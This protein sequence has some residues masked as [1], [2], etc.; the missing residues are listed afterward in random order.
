MITERP[1]EAMILEWKRI[2]ETYHAQLHPNRKSGVQVDAYFR[3]K[4]PHIA[5]EDAVWASGAAQ[6]VLENAHSC[7]KL[8]EGTRPDI[9]CYRTG[10]ALV[11]ID[12]VTGEFFVECEDIPKAV[13]IYDDLFVYRGMDEQDLGNYVLTAEYLRLTGII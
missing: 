9:R 11:S 10:A 7:E 8:P 3:A 12:L 4:Y 6:C 2:Y 1:T 13:P 5:V